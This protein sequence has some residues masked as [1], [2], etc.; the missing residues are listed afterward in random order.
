MKRYVNTLTHNATDHQCEVCGLEIETA[1][2]Y[3]TMCA[4]CDEWEATEHYN[5]LRSMNTY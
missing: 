2:K 1:D 3:A 5:Q 4:S